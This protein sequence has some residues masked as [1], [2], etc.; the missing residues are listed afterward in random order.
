MAF[1]P[2][3]TSLSLSVSGTLSK[4]THAISGFF[5]PPEHSAEQALLASQLRDARL[6]PRV[7]MNNHELDAGLLAQLSNAGMKRGK[8]VTD[9]SHPELMQ[10]FRSMSHRA[11]LEKTPQLIIAESDGLNALTVTKDE[12]VI[13]TG[14][15]KILDLRETV[16]V[17][18]HE[19]G[20]VTSDHVKPRVMWTG[21]LGGGGAVLGNEFGRAGG[22]NMALIKMGQR[23]PIF[24]RAQDVLYGASRTGAPSSVMGSLLYIA[25]GA[26]AGAIVAR[27]LSVHPTEMDADAKGAAIS[28]DPLALASAL[29]ALQNHSTRSGVVGKLN[30]LRSG[31]PSMDKRVDRL[32]QLARQNGNVL[33]PVLAETLPAQPAVATSATEEKPRFAVSGIASAERVGEVSGPAIT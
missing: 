12:V 8:Q 24:A 9:A 18:G 16:A 26:S 27:H 33:S 30:F 3:S 11:G 22:L 21:V 32:E 7:P 19:L 5:A 1:N 10:A 29:K 23:W 17:L 25:A 28:G 14:L 2:D 13:T 15:L 6:A 4:A 20:H 31:Y